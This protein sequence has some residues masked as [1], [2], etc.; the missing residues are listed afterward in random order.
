VKPIDTFPE[1]LLNDIASAT[2]TFIEH[3]Q[4]ISWQEADIR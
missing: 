3:H 2:N 4:Y 1:K